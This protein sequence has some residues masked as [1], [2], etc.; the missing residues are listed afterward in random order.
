MN[1]NKRI[2]HRRTERR[3]LIK[4]YFDYT[5]KWRTIFTL[6]EIKKGVRFYELRN[7]E[8]RTGRYGWE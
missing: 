2:T 5:N 3:Q 7:L 1:K 6:S 8:D 4:K